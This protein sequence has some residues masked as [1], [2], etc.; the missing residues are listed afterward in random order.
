[1]LELYTLQYEVINTKD[2]ITIDL[3]KDGQEFL[4]KFDINEAYLLDTVSLVYKYLRNNGKIPHNLYKFFIAA[5]YIISRH[6]FAFP[7]HETKKD[8]CEKFGL[9]ISAL[10]YC[11]EKIA[12]TLNYIRILDDMNFPYFI[13]PKRDISLNFIKNLIKSKVDKAMIN[14]LIWHQP[15]NSQILTEDLVNEI[16]FEQKAFPEELLRQLFEITLEYVER[17]FLE[18]NEY[19]KLQKRVFI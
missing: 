7:M 12:D 18:Y 1:M 2:R 9:Q 19:I 17:E 16:I 6:P 11:V 14:F 13:N 8:F 5:Y 4:Q 15:I 10:D 3:I